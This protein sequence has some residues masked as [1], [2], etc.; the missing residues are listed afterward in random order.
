MSEIC[1]RSL[2]GSGFNYIKVGNGE[3]V[4]VEGSNTAEKLGLSDLRMP[5]KQI[6]KSRIILKPGQVNY[7]LNFL[8]LGD[9]ANF[10]AMKVIY[11][12]KSKRES[13][14]YINWSFY[15]N[16]TVI[17][18]INQLMILTGNSTNRIKQI[19][20]TNP[21]SKYPV[22]IEVMIGVIDDKTSFFTDTLNQTGTSFVNLEWSDIKSHIVGESIVIYDKSTPIRPLIY[23]ILSNVQSITKSGLV[24]VINDN[25]LGSIFLQFITEYDSAQAYSLLNYILENPNININNIDSDDTKPVIYFNRFVLDTTDYITLNGLTSSAPYNTD[26]GLTFSTQIGLTS[27]MNGDLLIDFLVDYVND[28]RDGLIILGSDNL[29]ISNGIDEI[30]EITT[31]GSFTVTFNV[32]DLADNQLSAIMLLDII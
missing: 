10:L 22:S 32:S 15:D 31:T 9:N 5:Y 13:E 20:L 2:F 28:D 3:L 27:S 24:L 7:L 14:N 4:A 26:N 21:N 11:D 6:L 29:V 17:N 16:L 8:G 19:Y 18:S 1:G 30:S 25:S 12:P 23:L